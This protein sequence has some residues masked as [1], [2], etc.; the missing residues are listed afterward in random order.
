[1]NEHQMINLILERLDT[2]EQV[3]NIVNPDNMNKTRIDLLANTAVEARAEA[4]KILLAKKLKKCSIF[5]STVY[6]A[7]KKGRASQG[8]TSFYVEI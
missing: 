5:G 7:D 2:I 1:M 6:D 3:L 4:R 8:A